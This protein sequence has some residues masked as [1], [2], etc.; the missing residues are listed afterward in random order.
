MLHY[1]YSV[2]LK[3]LEKLQV[4]NINIYFEVGSVNDSSLKG[5]VHQVKHYF[6]R[7]FYKL[8]DTDFDLNDDLEDQ[9]SLTDDE[10]K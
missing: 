6:N 3:V 8:T 10:L 5:K 4:S 7:R 1:E 9:M 2:L